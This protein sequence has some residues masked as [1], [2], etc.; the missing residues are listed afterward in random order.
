MN[1]TCQIFLVNCCISILALT[2][3][4]TL[5]TDSILLAQA[6]DLP[7][8]LDYN[9]EVQE[10]VN[11]LD[12]PTDMAFLGPDDLIILEQYNGTVQRIKDGKMLPMSLLDVNVASRPGTERGLLGIEVMQQESGHPF[13]FLYYTETQSK[14]GGTLL[15]NR[16][17]RYVFVDDVNGGKLINKTLLLDLPAITNTPTTG[18]IFGGDHNG[19][20]LA[21]GPDGNLYLTIGDV[22]H[23]TEIQNFMEGA[24]A[25]GT[26]GILRVTPNGDAVDGGILGSTHPLD[27]Y[28]AYGI[29]NSFGIDFDPVTGHLWDTENGPADYDEINLVFPG[30]NSGWQSTMG[31]IGNKTPPKFSPDQLLRFVSA[32]LMN[33]GHS[34]ITGNKTAVN[35]SIN[36]AR[37]QLESYPMSIGLNNFDGQGVYSD[38]EFVWGEPVGPTA[39]KFY[40]SSVLG[41]KY[42]NR[43][44]V[45]EVNTG[46][47]LNFALNSS[48]TGLDLR[49]NL[50]D[51]IA[52][53]RNQSDSII[54]GRGFG[55]IT[56]IE[57]GPDGFLYITD[58]G[59]GTVYRIVPAPG[60]E[61]IVFADLHI[62]QAIKDLLVKN[63]TG[64][65]DALA[66]ARERLE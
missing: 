27:K 47:I 10:Y 46:K 44:F 64:A 28:F 29:R 6:Q 17:Y 58:L 63:S 54:L 37:E 19:G 14:D 57:V 36:I 30:F 12:R 42:L 59:S 25:D 55:L 41:E 4:G 3:T 16:L 18:R 22:R 45:G 39:I 11:G 34:M 60:N 40:N 9:L 48:R 53:T 50:S 20:K 61:N 15:G 56:D 43:M 65:L 49:G 2:L 26:G 35:E 31:Y 5:F 52:D 8:L 7:V 62:I 1:A 33:A 66:Q 32:H 23:K 13:V 21:L 51:H 38:P 24:K